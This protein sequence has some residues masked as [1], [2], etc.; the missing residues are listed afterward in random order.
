MDDYSRNKEE[1][2]PSLNSG[3]L[4]IQLKE[5]VKS[6]AQKIRSLESYKLLCEERLLELSPSHS[7]PVL[8][9]HLGSGCP[10]SSQELLNSK[11]KIAKLEQQLSQV[12]ELV[13]SPSNSV[14]YNKLHELYTLLHQK[15]NS[16]IK[17]KNELEE[18]LRSETLASEEQRAYIEVLKQAIEI[19]TESLGLQGVKPEDFAEF[20]RIKIAN[21]ESRRETSKIHSKLVDYEAQ[22]KSLTESLKI[23]SN[24]CKDLAYERDELTDQLHQAAEALQYAEEEVTKLEE[25]KT[26]LL[27]YAESQGKSE[28]E[29]KNEVKELKT[30][31]LNFQEEN[32]KIAKQLDLSKSENKKLTE[33]AQNVKNEFERHEKTLKETQQSFGNLKSR[34]EEKD[35]T[36]SKYK[37]ENNNISI[38]NSSLQAENLN[39]ID[40]QKKLESE[41]ITVKNELKITK[42][43]E[44]KTNEELAGLRQNLQKT[45][46]DKSKIEK[47][48]LSADH[49]LENLKSEYKSLSETHSFLTKNLQNLTIEL[50]NQKTLQSLS[51][52]KEETSSHI[53][54]DLKNQN[55]HLQTELESLLTLHSRSQT[56]YSSLKSEYDQLSL[57]T[58]SLIQKNSDLQNTIKELE[59]FLES[60]KKNLAYSEE[61][62]ASLKY[63]I[64][65]LHKAA[66]LANESY[67]EI[68]NQALIT[69]A[70]VKN[71]SKILNQVQNQYEEE[72]YQK[73]EKIEEVSIFVSENEKLRK[74]IGNLKE[75]YELACNAA[76]S[77]SC[78][79]SPTNS[80]K[81]K[82]TTL[83]FLDSKDLFLYKWIEI[84]VQEIKELSTKYTETVSLI[85][86]TQHKNSLLMQDLEILQHELG[87]NKNRENGLKREIENFSQ[88]NAYLRESFKSQVGNLQQEIIGLRNNMQELYEDNEKLLNK[89]RSLT[90]E[91]SQI[92]A[93]F[94]SQEQSAQVFEN[95]YKILISEKAHL[96]A[97]LSNYKN[98]EKSS[99]RD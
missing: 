91:I 9:E 42:A 56:E 11:Q 41:L 43:E 99:F 32:K 57:N 84:A 97:V 1:E 13:P 36:I 64:E 50:E 69:K 79:L 12:I 72:K 19:K 28:Q 37:E 62:N 3:D 86:S 51:Q 4:L 98:S 39:L 34:I 6:Q 93:K 49:S 52:D 65:D 71:L 45:Q 88:E 38:Q 53:I 35:K 5:R 33:E 94:G 48:Y 75:L 90:N 73:T 77:A 27:D 59:I 78:L 92:K 81:F 68:E 74:E 89:N 96:E 21:E 63:K 85:D 14:T 24:E 46:E 16:L 7:L 10:S 76:K 44:E 83:E 54:T 23:K 30:R 55:F 60:E 2:S 22:I 25:E 87:S 31:I 82:E 15:Y 18:S 61:I 40:L 17:E 66:E 47:N 26:N 20:S 95:K 58:N 80:L 29:L 8:P 67:L 70:E